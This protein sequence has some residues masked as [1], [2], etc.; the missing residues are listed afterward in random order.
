MKICI[1]CNSLYPLYLIDKLLVE[2]N[3]VVVVIPDF[4]HQEILELKHHF[5]IKSI[6]FLQISKAQLKNCD[7]CLLEHLNE[8]D[9][10]LTYTFPWLIPESIFELIPKS[11]NIHFSLLPKYAGSDPVFWQIKNGE[12]YCGITFQYLSSD[13]DSG[14]IICQYKLPIVLGENYGLLS[15][16]LSLFVIKNWENFIKNLDYNDGNNK[17]KS[18]EDKF[19]RPKSYDVTIDWNKMS[20]KEIEN[21]VNACN[22]KY[23]GA[24][25]YIQNQPVKILEVSPVDFNNPPIRK[26]G[27]IIYSDFN[28]G[29]FVLCSDFKVL[30]INVVKTLEGT[31]S[32]SKLCLIGWNTNMTFENSP[33]SLDANFDLIG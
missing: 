9:I 17:I 18:K 2:S 3:K 5:K 32:S 22:P 8:S 14:D 15:L 26:A 29:V 28:Q 30:K 10:L 1:F 6:S 16:R 33:L 25:T 4:K 19:Y 12:S 13:F 27:S 21:L 7:P 31:L 23:E 24:L 11:V 20:A